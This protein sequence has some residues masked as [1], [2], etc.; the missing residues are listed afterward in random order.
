MGNGVQGPGSRG[1]RSREGT[2]RPR[3]LSPLTVSALLSPL[4]DS[5]IHHTSN[6]QLGN[7]AR[8][9]LCAGS[10][11]VFLAVSS[12]ACLGNL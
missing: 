8:T 7:W 4:P 3:P 2:P 12:V 5:I 9:F 11:A 6:G 10:S 1:S